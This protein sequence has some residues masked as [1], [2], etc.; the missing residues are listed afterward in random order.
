MFH[1]R[2][3]VRPPRYIF[4]FQRDF[5]LLRRRQIGSVLPK[6]FDRQW[7][8]YMKL[9]QVRHGSGP[10]GRGQGTRGRRGTWHGKAY[11]RGRILFKQ[12]YVTRTR[13]GLYAAS[14][15]PDVAQEV[16]YVF[17]HV[18]DYYY[19]QEDFYHPPYQE[20]YH[21]PGHSGSRHKAASGASQTSTGRQ[22]ETRL[23]T[24]GSAR[25]KARS[26]YKG[27]SRRASY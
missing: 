3:T 12:N 14:G 25:R 15:R 24:S 21:R 11:R 16:H 22:W 17:R 1:Q 10:S 9:R 6:Y 8:Q 7:I 2:Q 20:E 19:S 26:P 4:S 18:P 13:E 27:S 23:L 5:R